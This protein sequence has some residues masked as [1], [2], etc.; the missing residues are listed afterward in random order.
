MAN[1]MG[2]IRLIVCFLTVV[3]TVPSRPD[4]Q[5]NYI[6]SARIRIKKGSG[7]TLN[8]FFEVV[9]IAYFFPP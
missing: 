5:K 2:F 7:I 6:Y 4:K 8:P 1:G 9:F 3:N